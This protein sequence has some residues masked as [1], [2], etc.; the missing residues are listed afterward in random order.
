MKEVI[1]RD[2]MLRNPCEMVMRSIKGMLPKN[3]MRLRYLKNVRVYAEAGHDL[4]ELGLPQFGEF[5]NIDYNK[6]LDL[7]LSPE[8]H[9]IISSNVELEKCIHIIQYFLIT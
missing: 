5:K 4:H 8:T 6:I 9:K 3:K 7:D 2:Y 1:A